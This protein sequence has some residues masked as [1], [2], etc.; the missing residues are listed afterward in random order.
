[1]RH[2]VTEWCKACHVC[3]AKKGP[4][5]KPQAP[6]QIYRVGA[7]ME[8]IAIDIASPLPTTSSGNRYILVAMDYFTKWPETYAIPNQEATTVAKKLVEFFARFGIPNELHSDQGRN[9]E[10]SVFK[11]CCTLMGVRKTRTTAL[12]PESDGMVERFN[13]TLGQQLA[14]FCRDN[15]ASWDEKLPMLIMAY[16]SAEHESTGYTPA[17]LMN[18][19]ELRLPSNVATG[20]PPEDEESRTITEYV[21]KIKRNLIEVHNH[22]RENLKI[23]SGSMKQRFDAKASQA[24]LEPGEKVWLYNPRRKRGVCP[25]LSSD[26]EGPYTIVNRLSDVTYRIKGDGRSK[27][28]V[29]HFNRLWKMHCPAKFTWAR[30]GDGGA[31]NHATDG[32]IQPTHDG[33][34]VRPSGDSS[35]SETEEGDSENALGVFTSD[36]PIVDEEI[37]DA[38]AEGDATGGVETVQVG[39]EEE[40]V[41]EFSPTALVGDTP[42]ILGVQ[43]STEGKDHGN[44]RPSRARRAPQWHTDFIMDV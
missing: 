30:E 13:A 2:D 40:Q 4:Q 25:K 29:V 6:L 14:K 38:P 8:R 12:H 35:S 36:S 32:S 44:Q 43:I 31:G 21:E 10:S 39:A 41:R 7:P 16:R 26:W 3:C 28:K 37:E 19:R 24:I 5:R 20:V 34:H 9:F 11:E 33:V 42:D 27:P 18:G 22:V 15:Q 17:R 1:M 23:A